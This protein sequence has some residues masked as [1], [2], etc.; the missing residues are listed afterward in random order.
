MTAD[1]AVLAVIRGLEAVGIPYML[2][3]SFS[4]N[5]YGTPRSTQDV[6][7]VIQLGSATLSSLMEKLGPAFRLDPQ[8]T[9]E[10]VTGTTKALIQLQHY[11]FILVVFFLSDAPPDQ[12]RF[13]RRRSHPFL[14][15]QAFVP[16]AED[17]VITK[18]R[19]FACLRRGKDIDDVKS[20]LHIQ[21]D[22]LDWDY[23]RHWCDQHGTR[24]LL[25][26][27]CREVRPS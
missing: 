10:S 16:P 6:D 13:R 12:E 5:V 26:Q 4:S 15:T 9:F 2:V 25:E 8:L 1:E 17:V 11:Y 27:V 21:W 19:W 14:G 24:E 20:V 3:G 22:R 18:L 7:L 23:I